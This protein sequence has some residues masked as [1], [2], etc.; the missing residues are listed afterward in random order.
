[1]TKKSTRRIIKRKNGKN[2]KQSVRDRLLQQQR[3]NQSHQ[4]TTPNIDSSQMSSQL[5]PNSLR[6]VLMSGML[7]PS[8]GYHANQYGSV[9]PNEQMIRNLQQANQSLLND[10]RNEQI[11]IETLKKETERLK[12]EKKDIKHNRDKAEHERDMAADELKYN[13]KEEMETERLTEQQRI[14]EI[15]SAEIDAKN[16]IK[17]QKAK[18][19][20]L[21]AANHQKELELVQLQKKYDLNV[22]F[23]EAQKEQQEIDSIKN[24]ID[25]YKQIMND[26][27]FANSNET[28]ITNMKEKLKKQEELKQE[29]ALYDLEMEN[30]E[31]QQSTKYRMT[32][33]EI[34]AITK[35]YQTRLETAKKSS[36]LYKDQQQTYKDKMDMLDYHHQKVVEAEKE[37]VDERIK[38][39][40][41]AKQNDGLNT[42]LKNISKLEQEQIDK[43]ANMRNLRIR[44]EERVK[45]K[46]ELLHQRYENGVLDKMVELQNAKD[47]NGNYIYDNTIDVEIANEK[48]TNEMM[49]DIYDA[50]VSLNKE[51]KQAAMNKTKAKAYADVYES[52]EYK[53]GL[54]KNDALIIETRKIEEEAKQLELLNES[55]KKKH[56]AEIAEALLVEQVN[57]GMNEIEQTKYLNE[58]ADAKIEELNQKRQIGLNFINEEKTNPDMY[59][60]FREANPGIDAIAKRGITEKLDNLKK[61]WGAYQGFVANNINRMQPAEDEE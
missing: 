39:S 58:Q 49:K 40:I 12:K 18:N 35:Q 61:A 4:S 47:Q 5:N 29:K 7:T 36:T 25:V 8:M 60:A 34:E 54:A 52:K 16:E 3:T 28:Y 33:E 2:V 26:P 1:M 27:S 6:G 57:K 44:A 37:A 20:T 55:N 31:Q 11:Q 53:E 23:A 51:R 13:E 59:N 42:K 43:T 14:L 15:R 17:A 10:K 41:A 30:R 46:T 45:Q 32:D 21:A 48:A 22:M 24:Q 19:A 38:Y 50:R 56:E 9:N